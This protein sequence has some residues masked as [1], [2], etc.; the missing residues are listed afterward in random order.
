MAFGQNFLFG[1]PNRVEARPKYEPWQQPAF[2]EL[3]QAGQKNLQNP[4]EGFDALKNRA[5]QYFNQ[6]LVPGLMERFNKS[7]SNA[8]SS[9]ALKS[10]LSQAGGT[11]AERLAGLENDYRQ[12][13]EN[14]GLQ[15]IGL[16]LSPQ[17]ESFQLADGQK[18]I[19]EKFAPDLIK[20]FPKLLDLGLNY[21]TGGV[22]GAA[23]GGINLLS[24]LLKYL[25]GSEEENTENQ[26]G[27]QPTVMQKYGTQPSKFFDNTSISA[28]PE[29]PR[30]IA[31]ESV[32][33][34]DINNIFKWLAGNTETDSLGRPLYNKRG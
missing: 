9:G 17:T 21:A 34:F 6:E 31:E 32:P 16:G 23:T 18:G 29:P 15:Q 20:M 4:L 13:R 26:P 24:Q 30:Q 1:T 2:M 10:E 27:S 12:G 25:T 3:L 19:L 11:L 5:T 22:S 14:F 33:S 8:L 28:S 7:G